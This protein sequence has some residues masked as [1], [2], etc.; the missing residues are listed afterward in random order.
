M[1]SPSK[2]RA[3][4]LRGSD[5]TCAV[6]FSVVLAVAVCWIVLIE[7]RGVGS[8]SGARPAA[9]VPR[10]GTEPGRRQFV[11]RVD[12]EMARPA[13]AERNEEARA[14][15]KGVFRPGG[16]RV[17]RAIPPVVEAF[18]K[19]LVDWHDLLPEHSSLWER[20]GESSDENFNFMKLVMKEA[21]VTDFL[22]QYEESGLA[23]TFGTDHG[24]LLNYSSCNILRDVC[25]VHSSQTC[26]ED[27]F[28]AW[29]GDLCRS[30][31]VGRG[32]RC[33]N[34]AAPRIVD[35][36]G[37]IRSA[38]NASACRIFVQE[39]A[40]VV[41]VDEEAAAM[42]YHW[43]RFFRL[44]YVKTRDEIDAKRFQFLI[45]SK[46][47]T[48]F[49]HYFGLLSTSCWRRP[50]TQLPPNVCFCRVE[51]F[52]PPA[53]Q[54]A[55]RPGGVGALVGAGKPGGKGDAAL[56]Q[57]LLDELGLAGQPEPSRIRV[58]IISRRRKRFILNEDDL[59][60]ACLDLGLDVQVL[61][62]EQMTLFEQLAALRSVTV[63]VGI[64]GSG[65]NNAI[66]M[67]KGSVLVQLLP[68]KLNYKGAFQTNARRAG[69]E[70]V[71]WAL[72]DASRSRFHWEFVGKRELGHGGREAYLARG[73]PTGGAE[74]YTFWINQD[75]I[76]PVDEFKD[77]IVSAVRASGLNSKIADRTKWRPPRGVGSR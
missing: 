34:G 22:T 72:Q 44:V 10:R 76:V 27:S 63:L 1:H 25:T 24:S 36:N 30:A 64:H 45:K 58:G 5:K 73:S 67:H 54:R 14:S 57:L 31:S 53:A 66:F 20:F 69:V 75:I 23:R 71:E 28:C 18:R 68:Y 55:G 17:R 42:F 32:S 40:M 47:N 48:Q 65:L 6:A 56:I 8:E 9:S 35:E 62:L 15:E 50:K 39:K 43:W 3:H 52:P 12:E 51:A 7:W 77:L 19:G 29:D 46:T 37:E 13:E 74:V 59:V 61:P 33:E 11:R 4:R 21:K 38:Q 70:Y 41:D 60:D 26:E 16:R 2:S 49:F